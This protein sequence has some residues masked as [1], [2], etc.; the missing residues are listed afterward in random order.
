MDYVKREHDKQRAENE[1]AEN[2]AA[3]SG[4]DA[5]AEADEDPV[6]GTGVEESL[7]I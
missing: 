3:V 7:E 1:R 6:E 5:L 4:T 2:E